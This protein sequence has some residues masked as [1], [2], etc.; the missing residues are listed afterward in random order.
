MLYEKNK[1]K[2]LSPKLFRDPTSE[3]RGTPFWAWNCELSPELLK[4]EIEYMKDMGFGGFH[5]HPRVGMSTPYLTDE[6]MDLVGDCVEKARDEKMLAWLY[7]EDKWPSGYAGGYVTK[8]IENRQ[9][10]LFLTDV[11]YNDGTLVTEEDKVIARDDVPTYKYDLMT[12]FDVI[13]DE[14]YFLKSYKKISLADKAEGKKL[15][16][17]VEYSGNDPWFNDQAYC[18]TLSKPVV[19]EFLRSTHERYKARFGKE[20][21]KII[22]AIFTDEPQFARKRQVTCSSDRIRLVLPWTLDFDETYKAAFG[23]SIVDHIPE[24][25]WDLPDGKVSVNRYH[26]HDHIAERF[27]SAFADTVGAWC[28]NNGLLLTG[29]VMD[30]ASLYSQTRAVGDAMRSYRGFGMPGIDMLSDARELTTAKQAQSAA[31]QYGCPGVLSE[32]YGVTNW[33]FDFRGHKLQG[34]WQAALG[35]TVRVPHLFWVSMKGEAKRDYPAAIGYQS[36]WY[37]EYKYVEDHFA[38]VNTLMTRGTP[39]VKIAVIHPVESYWLHWGPNDKTSAIRGD[40]ERRFSEIT[41]WLLYGALD[42]DF[43]CESLLGSQFDKN[44]DDFSVGK[45]KYKAVVVPYCETMRK[46]TLDALAN[47]SARGGKV[48]FMG[49]LPKYI[50]AVPSDKAA[51]LAKKCTVIPWSRAELYDQ[52][53]SLRSVEIRN[54]NG[55]LSNNLI[56]QSR[57]DGDRKN[58]FIAHVE[59]PSKYDIEFTEKY[60]ITFTG[61]VKVTEYDTLSGEIRPMPA[62][63]VDGNTKIVWESGACSSLLVSLE[64]GRGAEATAGKKYEYTEETLSG[65]VDYKLSEPNVLMLDTP[66]YS[67]NGGEMNAPEYFIFADD[68]IRKQLGIRGRAAKMAQPWIKPYDKDPKDKVT[69]VYKFESEIAA[70]GCKLALE[71]SEY[72]SVTFN[73]KAVKMKSDGWYVD[74]D[75]LKTFPISA[76]KKGENELVI[77]YRFGDVTQIEACFIL[78]DFGTKVCGS[79]VFVTKRPA[80]LGFDDIVSQGLAFYGGNVTYMEKYSSDGKGNKYIEINKYRGSVITVDVDGKRAGT[81]AYPPYR[82]PLGKLPKGEH[83]IAVTIYGNRMNSFGTLHNVEENLP[84]CSPH[85]WRDTGRIFT[86]EYLLVE[87]GILNTPRI[88]TEK[89]KK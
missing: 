11:P 49:D 48:I 52:L 7:D 78:G 68:K 69:L 60:T 59:K 85:R 36:P 43:V 72:A 62:K 4:K 19:E 56:Y 80:K 88:I 10:Y 42:F 65:Y 31:H 76:I 55:E 35:I 50:D 18:D 73:G 66:A 74:E 45:M 12:C 79:N 38:R 75:A 28:R 8:N 82:L 30:E 33:T 20:F 41:N 51:K 29:H 81:I 13:L 46:T 15:F 70:S 34:D 54:G 61:E 27:V 17:Y 3:Y 14:E 32:L 39:D 25:V 64:N 5:M 9:K 84:Y 26:Y 21:G 1:E 58:V 44:G 77:E 67:V 87:T 71:S 16:V 22:P 24:L 57:L 40:M 63:Y 89:E 2:S 86:P 23:E 47:F 37:K 53:A 6:F 83:E